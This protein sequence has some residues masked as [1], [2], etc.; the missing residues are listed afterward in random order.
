MKQSFNE[1]WIIYMKYE[2]DGL[3]LGDTYTHLLPLTF[4]E[5]IFTFYMYFTV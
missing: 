2:I 3:F 4:H 1:M 5:L